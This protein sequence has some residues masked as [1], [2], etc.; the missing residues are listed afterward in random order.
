MRTIGALIFPDFELLDLYG[1]LEMFSMFPEE[2]EQRIVAQFSPDVPSSAGPRTAV[3]DQIQEHDDYDILLVP[4]GRGTRADV[5]NDVLIDWVKRAAAKAEI[6]ASVCTGSALLAKAGL[7]DGRAATT[8]KRAF[9]WV[10]GFGPETDWRKSARW[11]EDGNIFTASGVSAGT[12]MSLA[13]IRRLL[14]DDAAEKACYWAEYTPN[15]DPDNDPFA[16]D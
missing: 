13:V 12:D 5:D 3:D 6:V 14:G 2:F 15:N 9:D 8:N 16:V 11:V 10:A 7:L 4:G 1:P